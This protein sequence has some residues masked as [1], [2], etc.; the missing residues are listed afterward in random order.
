MIA[1][2][3]VKIEAQDGG[4]AYLVTWS[5]GELR[6][7]RAFGEFERAQAFCESFIGTSLEHVSEGCWWASR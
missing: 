5:R 1:G 3:H 6:H 2:Y 4:T 7:Y